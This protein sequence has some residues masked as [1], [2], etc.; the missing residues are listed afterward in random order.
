MFSVFT[1]MKLYKEGQIRLFRLADVDL[2]CLL[3]V[4]INIR[5]FQNCRIFGFSFYSDL[6][7]LRVFHPLALSGLCTEMTEFVFQ[8][9][10]ILVLSG[11]VWAPHWKV[12]VIH[13]RDKFFILMAVS[14]WYLV[15]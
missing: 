10:G 14:K 12:T 11:D 6:F 3:T 9:W 15:L 7:Y 4:T 1:H 2:R 8:A 5:T 13:I